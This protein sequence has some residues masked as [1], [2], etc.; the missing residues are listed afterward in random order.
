M[1][2]LKMMFLML[3]V[4]LITASSIAVAST[5]NLNDFYK[6]PSVTVAADGSS[7]LLQEDL[8][9]ASVLLSNDPFLGDPILPFPSS[10]FT[11]SFDYEFIV[12]SGN[13]DGIR[14]KLF[15]GATGNEIA[16]IWDEYDN[17]SNDSW[18]KSGTTVWNIAGAPST[19]LGLEFQLYASDFVAGSSLRVSNVNFESAPV[20]EPA[21]F[22]LLGFG[23]I[24]VAGLGRRKLNS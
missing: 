19:G 20:P 24:G 6:D 16:G 5:I 22:L 3:V 10:P 18:S 12:L 8:A 9:Y 7:A 21:S 2:D 17:G 4:F 11:L 15:D 23:M 13:H 1:K 14:I